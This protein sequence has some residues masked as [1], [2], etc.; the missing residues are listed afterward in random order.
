VSNPAHLIRSVFQLSLAQGLTWIGGAALAVLL[1]RFLGDVNLGKYTL[2]FALTTLIGLGADLGVATYL[3]REVARDRERAARLTTATLILRVP[4]S[5]VAA[6]AAIAFAHVAH[7]DDLTRRVLYVLSAGILVNSV[8]GVVFGTLQGLQQMKI[9]AITNVLS[10]VG[11]AGLAAVLLFGGAGPF[12]LASGYVTVS[13]FVLCV[14]TVVMLRHVRPTMEL[15][16]RLTRTVLL[17]GLPFF[18]WQAALLI[19]GQID[20]ILLSFLSTDAVVGWYAAAYRIVMIPVFMPTIIVT[21]V[22]PALSAAANDA[23]QFNTI[24]RRAVHAAAM[25]SIP[26]ALGIML[27]PDKIIQL[28][29]YPATFSH[30]TLPLILLAPHLP[31][32]AIDVMIGTVLNTRDKQ[33]QWALT[34]VAAAGLNPLLNAAAIPLAQQMLGNG[35]VGAAAITTLTEVFMMVVGLRLLPAGVFNRTTLFDVLKF[36]AAGIAMT[37]VVFFTRELPIVV[38]IVLGAVVYCA[39]CLILGAVSLGELNQVRLHLMQRQ[40]PA[41]SS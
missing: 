18:V 16:W 26:M 19:Y 12:E 24:A 38:P 37:G 25:V 21:V 1:P 29:G 34:A 33:R 39:A 5:I 35:A 3:T 23:P 14:A 2:A 41:V 28:L 15:D 13:V 7:Y 6:A 22:F 11:Y 36:L 31:V 32:A 40:A 8:S 27:L 10:K 20:T 4:L 30:S 17:G 9:M